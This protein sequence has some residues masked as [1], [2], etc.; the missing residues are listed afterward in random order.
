MTDRARGVEAEA[1]A[2]GEF[3]LD[4]TEELRE[5]LENN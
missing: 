3:F 1:E 5:I 4:T 2:K